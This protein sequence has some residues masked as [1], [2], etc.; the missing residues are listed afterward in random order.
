MF[1]FH[2]IV[3]TLDVRRVGERSILAEE[4]RAICRATEQFRRQGGVVGV[5]IVRQNTRASD[6]Q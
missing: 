2:E 5:G 3:V 1:E 4:Q 6:V